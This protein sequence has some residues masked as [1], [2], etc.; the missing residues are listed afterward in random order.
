MTIRP[1]DKIIDVILNLVPDTLPNKQ[2]L[3]IELN[4]IKESYQYTAP[5][6]IPSQWN[7]TAQ[8]LYTYLGS[9]DYHEDTWRREVRGIFNNEI[10][11]ID[12]LVEL[13]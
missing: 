8:V 7:K 13:Q 10:N 1:L 9:P 5:E 4:K 2:Y 3:K 11:Y 6:A 12:Y